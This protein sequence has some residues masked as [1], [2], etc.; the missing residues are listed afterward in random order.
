MTGWAIG[1]VVVVT[2]WPRR[3]SSA[4]TSF[5]MVLLSCKLPAERNAADRS[6]LGSNE[7]LM[8]LGAEARRHHRLFRQHAELDVIE[9]HI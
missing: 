2:L 8:V 7:F 3:A 5:A 6:G 9:Q 4:R 1:W